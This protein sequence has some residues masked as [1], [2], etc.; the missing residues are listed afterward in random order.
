MCPRQQLR[1]SC[2]KQSNTLQLHCSVSSQVCDLTLQLYSSHCVQ[3]DVWADI[4]AVF[5]SLSPVRCV[6]WHYSCTAVTVSSQV[7][8]LTLQLHSCRCVQSGVWPDV[9]ACWRFSDIHV[10]LLT[11][12]FLLSHLRKRLKAFRKIVLT[13]WL[14]LGRVTTQTKSIESASENFLV[15]FWNFSFHRR[16]NDPGEALRPLLL[17]RKM[18]TERKSHLYSPDHICDQSLSIKSLKGCCFSKS[19]K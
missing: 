15:N 7:C 9:L 14:A 10:K 12:D 13:A 6:T 8:E 3:S 1:L 4:T 17:T 19:K 16:G 5:F 18:D 2:R 11:F